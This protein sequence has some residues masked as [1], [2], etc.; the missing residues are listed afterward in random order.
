MKKLTAIV[1][2]LIL[3]VSLFSFAAAEG[4]TSYKIGICNFVDDASLN[5]IIANLTA[6]LRAIEAEKGVTFDIR[7]ENCN[8]DFDLLNQI[9]ANFI[10]DDVDLMVGVAT[11]V[12][13]T[14]QG[15]TEENGIPW[16]S[17]RY[18]TLWARG[19]WKAWRLPAPTSPAPPTIW[20]P[21]P[22]ST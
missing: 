15:M 22:C 16:C 17:P 6:Q 11:P 13:M 18:P 12:A 14:M 2:A 21:P 10:A 20:T 7:E 9:V 1:L 5:Q 19:L 3:T 4:K 8:I